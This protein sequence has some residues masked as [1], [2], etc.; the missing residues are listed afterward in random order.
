MILNITLKKERFYP[1]A[2]G[3]KKEY[4]IPSQYLQ[5]IE[6]EYEMVLFRNGYLG[7]SPEAL[8][9]LIDITIKEDMY[10]LRLGEV[11]STNYLNKW[12]YRTFLKE[13]EKKAS[14]KKKKPLSQLD[15]FN[16]HYQGV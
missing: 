7:G 16:N 11:K 9:E 6:K 13:A 3:K 8:V 12:D 14:L 1:I 4:R 2:S 10:I 5:R 15:L